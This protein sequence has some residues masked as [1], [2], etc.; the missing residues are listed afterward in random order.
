MKTGIRTTS[1]YLLPGAGALL[2][3]GFAAFGH[4][5]ANVPAQARENS[6]QLMQQISQELKSAR[7][8]VSKVD[9]DKAGHKYKL[10]QLL[11]QAEREATDLSASLP[12]KR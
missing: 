9:T 12:K 4:S 10:E 5:R 11:D 3:A 7:E 8:Q 2:L 1:A 6:E